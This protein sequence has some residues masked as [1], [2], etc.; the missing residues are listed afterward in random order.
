MRIPK[1]Q[2]EPLKN[3]L[4]LFFTQWNIE[5]ATIPIQKTIAAHAWVNL[6]F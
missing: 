2:K 5:S 4:S 3:G 1:V 6:L